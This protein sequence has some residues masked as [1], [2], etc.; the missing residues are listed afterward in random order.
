[1]EEV[2]QTPEDILCCRRAGLCNKLNRRR[3][4]YSTQVYRPIKNPYRYRYTCYRLQRY[5]QTWKDI[6]R[7]QYLR[8]ETLT[9]KD[10]YRKAEVILQGI[11]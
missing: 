11:S 9:K 7:F 2:V 8:K 6:G 1:L 5:R 4:L 10:K 3:V